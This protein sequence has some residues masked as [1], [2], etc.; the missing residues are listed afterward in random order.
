MLD[1]AQIASSV[2]GSLIAGLVLLSAVPVWW[3]KVKNVN[4][5]EDV[6][7]MIRKISWSLAFVSIIGIAV[8]IFI[9]FRPAEPTYRLT[10]PD[11]TDEEI[12]QNS[13]ECEMKALELLAQMQGERNT[14]IRMRVHKRYYNLC[15]EDKGIKKVPNT[16]LSGTH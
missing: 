2:I 15:L 6:R 7:F 8:A 14:I 13:I 12:E 10:H 9:A 3:R 11:M 1:T 16:D 4:L 5:S